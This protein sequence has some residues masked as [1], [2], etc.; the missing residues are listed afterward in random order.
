MAIDLTGKSTHITNREATPRVLN[1]P[2]LGS[3]ARVKCAKSIATVA[4]SLSITSIIRM[5][6]VPSTSIVS[7]VWFASAAQV[8][9]KFDIGV[10]RN[11]SDGGAVVSAAFF[12]SAVDCASAVALTDNVNESLSNTPAKQCQPLWQ[13]AGL[14]VDPKSTLDICL[15]VVTTDVT[16]GTGAVVLVVEYVD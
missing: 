3:G 16:T 9:G 12:A 7:H 15:T 10:Y 13:A 1:N 11:N 2:G 14:S 5:V 8:A 4:A 6:E